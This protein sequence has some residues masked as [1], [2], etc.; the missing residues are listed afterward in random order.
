MRGPQLGYLDAD[1]L[2]SHPVNDD[3]GRQIE[4]LWLKPK[5][6]PT[7]LQVSQVETAHQPAKAHR[8][9]DPWASPNLDLQ[10][11]GG[12]DGDLRTAGPSLSSTGTVM[13]R[14]VVPAARN[15]I[16]QITPAKPSAANLRPRFAWKKR[17]KQAS[18]LT[19]DGLSS[20]SSVAA[21]SSGSAMRW[22]LPPCIKVTSPRSSETTTT[23]A[24]HRSAR[25][26]AVRWRSVECRNVATLGQRQHDI[27]SE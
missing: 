26:R 11:V 3:S 16:A 7:R 4:R 10:R 27:R 2:G 5:G 14:I 23:S 18:I 1:R 24:S 17:C 9:Y 20:P 6:V 13:V 8:V 21:S 25:P 15:D 19:P 12:L 22:I